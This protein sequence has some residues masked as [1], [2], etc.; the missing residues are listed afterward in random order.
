[1]TPTEI[2]DTYYWGKGTSKNYKGWNPRENG[3]TQP[4]G[5]PQQPLMVQL[6]QQEGKTSWQANPLYQV[7][8]KQGAVKGQQNQQRDNGK[9]P[10]ATTEMLRGSFLNGTTSGER[11]ASNP[12]W[13]NQ[14][15]APFMQAGTNYQHG[16]SSGTQAA[17]QGVPQGVPSQGLPISS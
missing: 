16:G 6:S 4:K 2:Q 9:G 1:M 17:G 14:V 3:K 10:A 8:T 5:P 15:N 7:G 11:P 13:G 12:M